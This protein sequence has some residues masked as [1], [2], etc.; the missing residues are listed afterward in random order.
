M[1]ATNVITV[2]FRRKPPAAPIAVPARP[3]VGSPFSRGGGRPL[4]T[5]DLVYRVIASMTWAFACWLAHV[6]YLLGLWL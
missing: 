3:P 6:A 4:P 1:N 2:D 5:C